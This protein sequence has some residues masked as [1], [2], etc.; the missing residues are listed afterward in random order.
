MD[1]DDGSPQPHAHSK[2]FRPETAPHLQ[3]K[4]GPGGWE[5]QTSQD[6]ALRADTSTAQLPRPYPFRKGYWTMQVRLEITTV[7]L[8]TFSVRVLMDRISTSY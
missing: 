8:R 5:K 1:G 4:K 7:F 2:R 3:P 6:S